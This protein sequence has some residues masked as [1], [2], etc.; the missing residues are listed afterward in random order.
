MGWL[1]RARAEAMPDAS[2]T[3]LLLRR[4]GGEARRIG[5]R[6]MGEAMFIRIGDSFTGGEAGW[7]VLPEAGGATA[8]SIECRG[9]EPAL[10][11]P[12]RPVLEAAGGVLLVE[13]AE[14]PAA[15][16]RSRDGVASLTL[17]EAAALRDRALRHL[18]SPR[19]LPVIP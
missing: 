5:L 14:A 9:A 16:R 3:A 6:G 19:D 2:G 12:L 10:R 11:G 18:P 17:A 15:L 8:I 4:P 7:W 1:G 13:L